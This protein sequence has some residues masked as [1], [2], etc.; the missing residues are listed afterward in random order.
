METLF[1]K[2]DQFFDGPFEIFQKSPKSQKS[3]KIVFS[4]KPK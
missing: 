1:P 4:Q 2:S 3:Q